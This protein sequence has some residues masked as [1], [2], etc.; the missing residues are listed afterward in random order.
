MEQ[1]A[2]P[3][4]TTLSILLYFGLVVGGLSTMLVNGL[5]WL[6]FAVY[7]IGMPLGALILWRISGETRLPST[8]PYPGIVRH[9][10]FG[11][12]SAALIVLAL[13]GGLRAAGWLHGTALDWSVVGLIVGVGVQQLV[14][15]GIEEFTFRGV[16]Q[17]LLGRAAGPVRGLFAASL[18]F[19]LFHLPNII[20]QGVH[21]LHIP[22]T[23]AV[24]T[25]MGVV[26]GGAY[27]RT[28][29]HLALP[30][31]LHYG[32]N[33]A[34][35]GLEAARDLAFSG[36][37]WLTG[38]PAWFPESGMVGALGLA[39]LGVLVHRLTRHPSYD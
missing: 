3:H 15:A 22:L 7:T 6:T 4:R 12:V 32:W 28:Q 34:C 10:L 9:V 29:Q 38:T 35:F 5:G 8:G 31:A 2:A 21:G 25:L 13:D 16:I 14:V 17:T 36:P 20:H 30:I 19:G 37:R 33:T 27:I 24:L 11:A 1:M 39:A 23:V 26:F 18:L